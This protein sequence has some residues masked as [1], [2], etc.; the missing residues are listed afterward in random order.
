MK[1]TQFLKDRYPESVREIAGD[2]TVTYTAKGAPTV[3]D[4]TGEPI[5]GTAYQGSSVTLPAQVDFAPARATREKLGL[6]M[7]FDVVLFIARKHV[8]DAQISIDVGDSFVLPTDG[9]EYLATGRA[10]PEMQ[11]DDGFLR[12]MVPVQRNVGRR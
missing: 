6:E 1:P 10:V 12:Y 2:A 11:T 5:E 8:D 4:I 9:R 7:K 3:D